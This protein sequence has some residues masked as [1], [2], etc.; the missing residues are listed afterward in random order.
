MLG[1]QG[2]YAEFLLKIILKILLGKTSEA[3]IPTVIVIT[4]SGSA[5]RLSS[6]EFSMFYLYPDLFKVY[7]CFFH[8]P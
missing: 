8:R 6:S 5:K 7:I 2:W 4:K 3:L 1:I